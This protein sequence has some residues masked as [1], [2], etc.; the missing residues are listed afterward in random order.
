MPRLGLALSPLAVLALFA[1]KPSSYGEGITSIGDESGAATGTGAEDPGEAG[2]ADNGC[3]VGS[4]GCPCT[5]GGTC[6]PGLA[7]DSGVC[8][9]CPI[10]SEG[11]ECTAGG[12][13]DPGLI[14]DAGLCSPASGDGD[15][16]PGDGDPGDGDPGDGD[17]DPD[18]LCGDGVVDVGE[19]CDLGQQNSDTGQ[20]TSACTIA[21]CGDGLV[22]EGFEECD[23]ANMDD[24]D[25]CVAGCLTAVC[26]DGFVQAGVEDCDDANMVDDDG[27][28]NDC[29][30]D[31]VLATCQD[32]LYQ[33]PMWEYTATGAD[34]RAFTN[35]T[36]HFIGCLS[37][38]GCA[39]NTFYCDHDPNAETLQFGTTANSVMRA[40]VD[41]GNARG[42]DIPSPMDHVG[43]CSA[44]MG[45]CNAPDSTN[46]GV[47]V[48]MVAALCFA[49]GYNSGTVVREVNSNGCPEVHVNDASGQ[50]W[51]SDFANSTGY[52]A[53]YL[54]FN[55]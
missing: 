18:P 46:N 36:L 7:C 23:D 11:C 5:D 15:G 20:C 47:Q 13:C 53:E 16:D 54:C 10:G 49:L 52:G 4:E 22:Y 34:L 12:S 31:Q 6:D 28:P 55:Q 27:C 25:D 17:G 39:E 42:D 14:C 45:S 48:D 33:G 24:T 3:P 2:S 43:C 35:S 1:C 41:T 32:I 40:A 38:N 21:E 44:P 50:D 29:T 26:G 30:I 9:D 8:T 51:D 37:A 19:E